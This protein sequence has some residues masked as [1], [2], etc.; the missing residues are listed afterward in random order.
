VNLRQRLLLMFAFVVFLVVGSVSWIVA[1]RARKAFNQID[2]QRT[3]TLVAQYRTEFDR[4]GQEVSQDL[5]RLMNTERMQRIGFEVGRGGDTAQFVNEAAALAQEYRFDYLDL[6]AADGTILSSAEWP[7]HFGY[8]FPSATQGTAGA[9]LHAFEVA[10]GSAIG[11]S[12]THK[13]S[14]SETSL[15]VVGGR[16]IDL[17]FLQNFVVGKGTYLWFYPVHDGTPKAS[18]LIGDTPVNFERLAEV[19]K[20]AEDGHE[21]SGTVPISSDP[22]DS[23]TVQSVPLNDDLGKPTLVLLIGT[24]RRPLLELQQQIRTAA[25][26]IA[27][28]GILLAIVASLWLAARFTHPIEQ[29]AAASRE[30]AAGHWDT[31]VDIDSDD[32]VGE[33][34]QSFNSMVVDLAEHRDRLV[35][36][37]RVAA[38]RELARRLAH[39]LKNPLFPLQLTVENLAKAKRLAPAEF[40]EIF[41]ESTDTLLAEIGNLKTIIG[42]FSDFSKMPKPQLQSLNLNEA[43]QRVSALF[44]A[45]LTQMAHPVSLKVDLADSAPVVLADPEL[46]HRVLSNLVLNAIDAMPKGGDILLRVRDESDSGRIEVSDTGTGLSA[47]ERDR[48]FTPYYTTKSHGTGLGLAVAQSVITD[49]NGSI[50]VQ[51]EPGRGTTFTIHLP[52]GAAEARI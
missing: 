10:S 13:V 21:V 37:E 16:A 24:S 45:Q 1:N 18:R 6:V 11:L 47:E 44:Q 28:G 39:E 43:V 23:A 32:E 30:L 14:G 52:K 9:T 46:I 34:A 20:S 26:A 2:Q 31:H 48:L 49:H 50:S 27:G 22:F 40:D 4:R 29:L 12:A 35:Q 19:V 8:K 38:W 7:A 5:N 51:S 33:L 25:F 42:R 17:A 41:R 15:Y 3:A 36:I